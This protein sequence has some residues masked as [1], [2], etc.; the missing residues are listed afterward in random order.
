VQVLGIVS[1]VLFFVMCGLGVIPAVIALA[2]APG[3]RREIE[4]SGGALGGAGQ[5][6]TGTILAWITVGLT[7]LAVVA[8]IAVVALA[9]SASDSSTS[10][11]SLLLGSAFD[12]RA[13]AG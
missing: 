1:L 6:R 7:A 12:L 3:A 4:A 13:R 8:V 10:F 9:V 2:M 5:L 11:Q